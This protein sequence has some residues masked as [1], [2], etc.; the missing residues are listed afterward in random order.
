M[1][2]ESQRT[3]ATVDLDGQGAVSYKKN[4]Q[5]LQPHDTGVPEDI[6]RCKRDIE[7]LAES[8][9]GGLFIRM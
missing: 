5:R 7:S 9:Q 2:G 6:G 4:S 1:D 3:S 8:I